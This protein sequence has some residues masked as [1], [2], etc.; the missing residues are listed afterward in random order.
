MVAVQF[1][2]DCDD[3]ESNENLSILLFL[4]FDLG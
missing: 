3:M 1:H 4:L 2:S